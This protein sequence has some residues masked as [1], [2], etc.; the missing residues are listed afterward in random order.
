[1]KTSAT[2]RLIAVLCFLGGTMLG[3]ILT[4]V[5]QAGDYDTAEKSLRNIAGELSE[6]SD[7]LKRI[8]R[9]LD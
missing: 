4:G 6:I 9:K 8:E 1:M 2:G 5:A 7:T 3:S